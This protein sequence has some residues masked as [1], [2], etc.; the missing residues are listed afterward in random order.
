MMAMSAAQHKLELAR[1]LLDDVELSRLAPEQL[2]L[3]AS[4]LARLVN[5]QSTLQ[6]L[7]WEL[8]GY[9]NAVASLLQ[10]RHF[11]RITDEEKKLGHWLPLAGIQA[12]IIAMQSQIQTLQIPNVQLS[13]SSANP[14]EMVT[15]FAGQTA[16]QMSMP[17]VAVLNRLQLLTTEVTTLSS[18][19]SRVLAAVH[20]FAVR[21]YHELAF[22]GLAETIFEAQKSRVDELLAK[23]AP[24]VL[25]KIPAVYDRLGEG[26]DEALSQA[27][28][29]LRRM[30]MVFA[31]AV[32]PPSP[33][34]RELEGESYDIGT[35][36]SL[37]RIKLYLSDKGASKSRS[38]RL[39]KSLR[40]IYERASAGSKKD[41]AV[42]EARSLFVMAYLDLGEILSA[43]AE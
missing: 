42:D 15:G 27:M 11:G 22:S 24:D 31:D 30:I 18:I 36:R 17:A 12:K 28:N 20:A 26:D 2:L 5:D 3:K 6:W 38:E 34:K 10:M 21:V 9:P 8:E 33:M 37:N 41:I 4:R 35:E 25:E 39:T 14:T 23:H 43:T 29:T 1:E 7:T 32:Y 19:R 16:Q 40:S 13:L